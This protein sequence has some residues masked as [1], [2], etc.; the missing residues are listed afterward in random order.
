MV[1]Q[2]KKFSFSMKNRDKILGNS[3]KKG[4]IKVPRKL[5][6]LDLSVEATMLCII[7]LA[8]PEDFNP[9]IRFIKQKML[10]STTTVYKLLHTLET[11]DIISKINQGKPGRVAI[12]EFK[13]IEKWKKT[14]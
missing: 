10:K 7:L 4:Y 6:E 11:F 9:S 8:Q 13:E 2:R 5:F 12:Y 3:L 1:S 14:P